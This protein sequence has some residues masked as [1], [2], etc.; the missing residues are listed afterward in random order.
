[1]EGDNKTGGLLKGHL[2]FVPAENEEQVEGKIKQEANPLPPE[3]FKV[4]NGLNLGYQP[5]DGFYLVKNIHGRSASGFTSFHLNP[6]MYLST[7]ISICNDQIA[8]KIY[9]KHFS[10]AGS[11]ES[12]V[13]TDSTGFPLPVPIECAKNFG[14]ENEEPDETPFNES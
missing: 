2:V 5:A 13:L 1:M 10:E 3:A 6:N 12:A 8:R 11:I 7:G 14:G 9:I 4:S